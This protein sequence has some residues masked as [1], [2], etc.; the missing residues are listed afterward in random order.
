[1]LFFVSILFLLVN[2][3]NERKFKVTL[4]NCFI[5]LFSEMNFI[6]VYLNLSIANNQC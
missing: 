1:M 6:A 4:Q 3:A 2:D 5:F